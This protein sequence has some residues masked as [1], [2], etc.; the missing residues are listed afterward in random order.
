MQNCK[1]QDILAFKEGGD[2][3]Y[4]IWNK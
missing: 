2:P 3:A 4:V 1:S